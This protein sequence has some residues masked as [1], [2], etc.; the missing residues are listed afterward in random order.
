MNIWMYWWYLITSFVECLIRM[1]W[2]LSHMKLNLFW[3][4]FNFY[5]MDDECLNVPTFLICWF[6]WSSFLACCWRRG[7]FGDWSFLSY[8]WQTPVWSICSEGYVWMINNCQL[9]EI[10]DWFKNSTFL[11]AAGLMDLW[12]SHSQVHTSVQ[13]KSTRRHLPYPNPRLVITQRSSQIVDTES[14]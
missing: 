1:E 3:G 4:K 14:R 11:S 7:L 13:K 12:G 6:S 9:T 8:H 5:E 10:D 2:G